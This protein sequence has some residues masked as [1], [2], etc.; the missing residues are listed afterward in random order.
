MGQ[1]MREAASAET[2]GPMLAGGKRDVV[3]EV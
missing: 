3:S 2:V 1:L